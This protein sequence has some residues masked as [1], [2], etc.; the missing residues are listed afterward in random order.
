MVKVEIDSK[1]LDEL[2]RKAA[3][4]DKFEEDLENHLGAYNEELDDFE[5]SD[6]DVCSVGE[7]TLNFFNAWR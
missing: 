6:A 4:L 2:E 7:L 3:R 1:V 5:E